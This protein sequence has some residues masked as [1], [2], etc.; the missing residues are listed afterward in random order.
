METFTLYAIGALAA[1]V[2]VLIFRT[3]LARLREHRKLR[4]VLKNGREFEALILDA[5]PITPSVIRTENV[6][7]RVQ[8]LSEKPV[9]IRFDYDATYPE[10]R[11]LAIG[12]VI[13]IDV[14]PADYRTVL[15]TRKSSRLDPPAV[16]HPAGRLVAA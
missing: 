7:L 9:E 1:G 14:D 5:K 3:R 12:K 2:A 10:W 13:T 15:I 4:Q 8:L 16:A 6:R 11:E